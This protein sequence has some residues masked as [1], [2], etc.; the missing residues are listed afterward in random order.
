MKISDQKLMAVLE[1][2]RKL[3]DAIH[4]WVLKR[5]PNYLIPKAFRN[6]WVHLSVALD[7]AAKEES[8]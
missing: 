3:H 2:S 1:G 7:D 4:R 6:E 5:P 8:P